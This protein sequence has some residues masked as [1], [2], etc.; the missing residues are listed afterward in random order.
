MRDEMKRF[1]SLDPVSMF[2]MDDDFDHSTTGRSLQ[3]QEELV[4]EETR[5]V[6]RTKRTV[7][8][9]IIVAGILAT[10]GIFYLV[11]AGEQET[12]TTEFETVTSEIDDVSH[13]TASQ[14]FSIVRSLSKSVTA[15]ILESSDN[16][17]FPF[18]TLPHWH[19]TAEETRIISGA[20]IVALAP[21][22]HTSE[23]EAWEAYATAHQGWIRKGLD[24]CGKP[25]VDPGS[26]PEQMYFF[27]GKHE[28]KEGQVHLADYHLPI[29]QIAQAPVNASVV[30]LDLTTRS[31]FEHTAIDVMQDRQGILSDIC[32]FTYLTQ[33]SFEVD[34]GGAEVHPQSYILEP[35]FDSFED[36]ARVVAF[37]IAI[38]PWNNYFRNILPDSIRGVDVVVD[39][40]CGDVHTYRIDGSEV[41][42]RGIGDRHEIGAG[43]SN[44]IEFSE[45]A[46]FQG[47]HPT[48]GSVEYEGADLSDGTTYED[49]FGESYTEKFID[50]SNGH[51]TYV[52]SVHSSETLVSSYHSSDPALYAS[53]V[54]V[55]FCLILAL[56]VAYDRVVVRRQRKLMDQAAKTK[57]IVSS[58]FPE[59]VQ[60]RMLDELDE[61]DD[62]EAYLSKKAANPSRP[63][64]MKGGAPFDTKP[65]ADFFP[66]TTI[67]FADLVGFTAWSSTRE[68]AQVFSLL[69]TLFS[70]FDSIARAKHVFKVETVGDCYVAASGLPEPNVHHAEAMAEFSRL[71]L[72]NFQKLVSK[73]EVDLGPDT[74]DLGLRIGVHSGSV[75]AGVLRGEKSR[76]QLFGDTVNTASRIE[77]TGAKNRIHV[78]QE[79]AD[80]LAEAGYGNQLRMREEKVQAKGKGEMQTYWLTPKNAGDRGAGAVSAVGS[81][82]TKKLDSKQMRNVKWNHQNLLRLL[83]PLVSTEREQGAAPPSWELPTVAGE[84]VLSEVKDSI[85]MPAS[86]P[87]EEEEVSTVVETQ[88]FEYVRVIATMYHD[89]AFHNFDHASHVTMSVTK[90]LARISSTHT[91]DYKSMQY[92][93]EA[94]SSESNFAFGISSDRLTQFACAFA[95]LIHDVDHTGV[96]NTQL[97]REDDELA[98]KYK[99]ISVAE[100]NSV[101]IAWNLF[102]SPCFKELRGAICRTQDEFVRF[103]ALVVNMVMATD[104]MDKELA[105]LRKK[106][107]DRAFG[108]KEETAESA[109]VPTEDTNRRATI[110][111]EHLIQ[112]SDVAH[113][114]QHWHVYTKWNGCLFK[115]MYTAYVDG[116]LDKDPSIDWYEGELGFL[117]FYV[118]PLAKKLKECQ[119]FGVASDEYL[120]YAEKNRTEWNLKG[121]EV[122]AEHLKKC[123]ADTS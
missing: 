92:E 76:F 42:Y 25:D 53:V 45:F 4:H 110:V 107:W 14:A 118:I 43:L 60:K 62:T 73:M 106:R 68:P 98:E 22:V 9:V 78:S 109:A 66:D 75:T 71:C 8:L 5:V 44:D 1:D 61:D 48:D 115:E 101:D 15:T 36:D 102:M 11:R 26:I 122:V 79:T 80:L 121:K 108:I 46:R 59:N 41:E 51:C 33:Y 90:L 82:A 100:Q 50:N 17:T 64:S 105:T 38:F 89:N 117:D 70:K 18:V 29:W 84:T 93:D 2:S 81:V 24:A 67:M 13:F 72:T 95:A 57:A 32:D 7:F 19:V 37:I 10:V 112:A 21:L 12:F 85:P 86:I 94:D 96:P 111:I 104:V 123:Q 103:R 40:R 23:K 119:V 3:E 49:A 63:V 120:M 55:L 16:A 28:H 56:V 116:R 91:I 83:K 47:S 54:A 58:L 34:A 99:N 88:L 87:A 39:D 20:E 77:T 114:M 6:R 74:A 31:S 52:L 69:E 27:E 113:T 30:N 65:I 97:V 35:V